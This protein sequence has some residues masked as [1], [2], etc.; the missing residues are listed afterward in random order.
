M[1]AHQV[2]PSAPSTD[3]PRV[4]EA[5]R[6]VIVTTFFP[7]SADPHRTPFVKNLVKALKAQAGLNLIAPVAIAP[8]WI[9]GRR[10]ARLHN[11]PA[12]E[13]IEGIEVHHPKFLVLPKMGWF[14]GWGY[15]FAI[16]PVLARLRRAHPSLVVHAH[17][18]YPDAVGVAIACRWLKIPYLVTVHGSDLNVYAEKIGLRPQVRWALTHAIGVVAV[19][20]ALRAKAQTLMRPSVPSACIPCAGFDPALFFVRDQNVARK[21]LGIAQRTRIVIYVGHLVPIKAIDSLVKAWSIRKDRS[22]EAAFDEMLVIVGAGECRAALD[23]Q[24]AKLGV[25]ACVKFTGVLAQAE[26]SQWIA[27]ADVLCLPSR[28]EGMPNVIVEALATGVPVVASR[29]GGI[30]ELITEGKNGLLVEPERPEELAIALGNA[31]ERTWPREEIRQSVEELTWPRLA[32]RN[33]E[34]L[35]SILPEGVH[36]TP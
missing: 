34:F 26:V 12:Q 4:A 28:N 3:S 25:Q 11:V 31:L 33:L 5:A 22:K 20:A 27:A 9:S 15:F 23:E 24:V 16:R 19:S 14:S 18:G 8:A 2:N 10:W 21:A 35:R 6:L 1:A 13:V 17:C 36:K 32:A 30:P 7:N 29:V